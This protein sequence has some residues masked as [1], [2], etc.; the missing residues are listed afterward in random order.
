MIQAADTFPLD[1][2]ERLEFRTTKLFATVA[3]VDAGQV[4]RIG[5]EQSN[6]SLV[7]G[8]QMVLKLYRRLQ[9]GIGLELEIGRFL[10]E[11]NFSNTPAL[12]GGILGST[13]RE[14]NSLATCLK[15]RG[16]TNY[17]VSALT[18]I[19]LQ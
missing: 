17:L 11:L 4:R 18:A 10:A 12:L 1:E 8:N 16:N 3:E 5:A 2:D 13:N 9:R 15:T 14:T 6:S 19:D 7:L